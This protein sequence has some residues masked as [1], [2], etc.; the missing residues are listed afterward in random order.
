[1]IFEF[2]I[3]KYLDLIIMEKKIPTPHWLWL[4]LC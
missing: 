2:F 4:Q 3:F 1:M